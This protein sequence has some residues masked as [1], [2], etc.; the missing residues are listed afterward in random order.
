MFIEVQR[1]GRHELMF[2]RVALIDR[3]EPAPIRR[4]SETRIFLSDGGV[5]QAA[6]SYSAL[7]EKIKAATGQGR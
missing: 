4:E 5:I 6:E 2:M 1:T 3:I 7:R